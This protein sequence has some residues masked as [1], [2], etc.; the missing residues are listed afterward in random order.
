[1]D[2]RGVLIQM[3]KPEETTEKHELQ[4]KETKSLQGSV[5]QTEFAVSNSEIKQQRYQDK[6]DRNLSVEELKVKMQRTRMSKPLT[7]SSLLLGRP[8]LTDGDKTLCTGLKTSDVKQL[9]DHHQNLKTES[10]AVHEYTSKFG[11][12]PDES[13]GAKSL[14]ASGEDSENKQRS[15]QA[16][17]PIEVHGKGYDLNTLT[18][19]SLNNVGDAAEEQEIPDKIAQISRPDSEEFHKVVDHALH[20]GVG[21]VHGIVSF[22]VNTISGIGDTVRLLNAADRELHP[23][24]S[25][26][27]NEDPEGTRKL[28]DTCA[29]MSIGSR[30]LLQYS[31]TINPNSPLYGNDFDPDGRQMATRLAQALPQ[32]LKDEISDFKKL[33]PEAQAAKSTE[34]MLNIATAAEASGLAIAKGGQMLKLGEG[35]KDLATAGKLANETNLLGSISKDMHSFGE[36]LKQYPQNGKLN[37]LIKFLDDNWPRLTPDSVPASG[38]RLEPHPSSNAAKDNFLQMEKGKGDGKSHRRG[39]ENQRESKSANESGELKKIMEEGWA[40]PWEA[41]SVKYLRDRGETISKNPFEGKDG[42]GRQTDALEWELKSLSDAKNRH[43]IVKGIVEHAKNGAGKLTGGELRGKVFIDARDQPYITERMAIK[44]MEKALAEA[45]KLKVIRIVG[46]DHET[47]KEF[48]L[49]R[50]SK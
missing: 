5:S 28:H 38:P 25:M 37:D 35:V 30:V 19:Q 50:R 27:P 20:V 17:A 3:T 32:K 43:N 44:G 31:T 41:K 12:S 34:L 33:P 48:D 7:A 9:T 8:E 23:V 24:R 40:H 42:A 21:E 45:S 10:K 11:Q 47:G 18:A 22:S 36:Q 49:F 1:M 2:P 4:T 13:I 16:G 39:G 29:A 14:T 15:V 46:K 6:Q 26:L